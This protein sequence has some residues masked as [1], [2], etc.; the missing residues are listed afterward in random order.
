MA[1]ITTSTSSRM[2]GQQKPRPFPAF[3]IKS[4]ISEDEESDR[5]RVSNVQS[6]K[7]VVN[8]FSKGAPP[9]SSPYVRHPPSPPV[10]LRDR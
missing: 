3:P 6:E 10:R 7:D 4:Q 1:T 2:G 5:Y 8:V 9:N